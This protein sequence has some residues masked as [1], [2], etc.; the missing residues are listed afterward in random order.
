MTGLHSDHSDT[1]LPRWLILLAGLFLAPIVLLCGFGSFFL[2]LEPSPGKELLV[3]TVA[4]VML[5]LSIWLGS[6]V[7]RLILGKP[8]DTGG[9]FSPTALRSIAFVFLIIPIIA[10]LTGSF[11]LISKFLRKQKKVMI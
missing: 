10:L 9:L 1:F 4:T 5:L 6:V 11:F 7:L 2:L 8:R 3:S